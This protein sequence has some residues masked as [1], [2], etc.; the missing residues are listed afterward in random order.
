MFLPGFPADNGDTVQWFFCSDGSQGE[1][2]QRKFQVW[3]KPRGCALVEV[4][5]IAGGGGG[6]GGAN[7][8]TAGGGGGGA[9]AVSHYLFLAADL[10][11][12][13][14]IWVGRPGPGG[15][16]GVSG[17]IGGFS[18]VLSSPDATAA[19][20][21]FCWA[22]TGGAG[23]GTSGTAGTGGVV[24][25]ATDT[26]LG[27]IALFQRFY[28]GQAGAAGAT[29]AQPTAVTPDGLTVGGGGGSGN[30]AFDGG[31]IAAIGPIPKIPGGVYPGGNGGALIQ[32]LPI[33]GMFFGGTGGA[34][35]D[36]AGVVGGAGGNGGYGCGGGGGG[37]SSA[38]GGAGGMG[39]PGL[40]IMACR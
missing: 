7:S 18:L 16:A 37:A 30:G 34:S 15:A 38:G 6:G 11:D 31:D 29:G 13:L 24:A 36:P 9:G 33:H 28:G 4:L 12:T 23:G 22:N 27:Q 35:G 19:G 1:G 40:V 10:P 39:G 14:Y 17:G 5:C 26:P 25:V 2:N 8:A 20:A 3:R 32:Q 21:R